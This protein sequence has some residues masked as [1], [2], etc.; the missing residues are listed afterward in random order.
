MSFDAASIPSSPA[1]RFARPPRAAREAFSLGVF[2]HG[3]G[4]KIYSLF[5]RAAAYP[6]REAAMAAAEVRA[7]AA[8]RDGQVVELFIQD[9][10]GE[11]SQATVALNRAAPPIEP[12][13]WP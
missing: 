6:S 5:E 4:W 2:N 12:D 3:G 10:N 8:A 9:D 1:A 7:R 11:F 13:Y